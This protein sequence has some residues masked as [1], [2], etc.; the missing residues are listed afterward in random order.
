MYIRQKPYEKSV[1]QS[2]VTISKHFFVENLTK[3]KNL[4]ILGS[5]WNLNFVF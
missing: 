2:C 5:N 3:T 4:R 1:T